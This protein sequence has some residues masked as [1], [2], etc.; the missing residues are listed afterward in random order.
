MGADAPVLRVTGLS[1]AFRGTHALVDVSLDVLP[2]EIHALV[3]HNGSGKSTLTK[4]LSGYHHPDR[5]SVAIRGTVV[6]LPLTADDLR[7]LGV[8]FVHQDLGLVETMSVV[9]N[10][11]VGRFE[12][13]FAGRV[14][15][16]RERE[17]ARQLLES[18]DLHVDPTVPVAKLSQAQRVI[19]AVMRALQD[20][21]GRSDSGLLVLDEPTSALPAGE[22]ELLFAAMRTVAASGVGILFVTHDLDEVFRITDRVTALRDGRRVATEPTRQ[23]T[24]ES[25]VELV[26][27]RKLGQLYPPSKDARAGATLLRVTGVS[28][29]TVRDVSFDLRRGE[30]L[31]LTGLIGAGQDEL[32]YLIY[33][34]RPARSA[35]IEFKGRPLGAPSPARCQEAGIVLVPSDRKRLSTVPR[36]TVTEN[37]TLPSLREFRVR[38][39]I[40]LGR[41][42]T[43]VERVLE[44]FD[45]RP[46]D[47]G[48]PISTLSGGNQQKVV[49]GRWLRLNPDV[50]LLHEPTQGVDIGARQAIFE[51][52]RDAAA[53]GTSILYA[54]A[55]YEDLA[56]VCD[57]VLVMYRG[58]VVSELEG[59][60]L[61]KEEIAAHCYGTASDASAAGSSHS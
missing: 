39:R 38:G 4:V 55:E 49:L 41:E 19:V 34:A 52:L 29:E 22:V 17:R 48:R 20:V 21:Q 7:R 44:R 10:L 60:R 58:Q 47:P 45:V 53:G 30:I 61:S 50:V 12:T 36:A 15:W 8:A 28:G 57:R 23:L 16:R 59:D 32:P 1:K 37:V 42:R 13:G 27:G 40:D 18:F 25:L 11:R 5:G 24:H 54:S 2:G 51:I 3:G 9:E 31:G 14:R 26:I 35:A 46:R 33:G 56:N 43:A 6:D